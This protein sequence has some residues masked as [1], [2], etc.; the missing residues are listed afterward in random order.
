MAVENDVQLEFDPI[1]CFFDIKFNGVDLVAAT[2]L[3]TAAVISVFTDGRSR[4]DDVIPN[5]RGWSGDSLKLEG[6]TNI[7]SRVWLLTQR[8]IDQTLV[9]DLEEFAFDSLEHLINA[10][11]ALSVVAVATIINRRKG[12]VNLDVDIEDPNGELQ[13]FKYVWDQ[14]RQR[15]TGEL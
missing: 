10:G 5:S 2:N 6:E 1:K 12:L 7:G 11:V 15:F 9:N 3:I 14:L 13:K 4:A 8:K